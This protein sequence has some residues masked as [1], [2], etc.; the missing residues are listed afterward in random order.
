LSR[1]D[2]APLPKLAPLVEIAVV[3]E[4][5]FRNQPEQAAPLDGGGDVVEAGVGE[6]RQAD[7]GE[8]AQVAGLPLVEQ[9]PE[10]VEDLLLKVAIEVQVAGGVG[11]QA[12]L[13]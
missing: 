3:G 7:E 6:E 11:A 8:G 13:G 2:F 12:Q 5:A 1:G 10:R 4:I 9:G